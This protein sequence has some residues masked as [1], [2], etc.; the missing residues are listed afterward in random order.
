MS[1]RIVKS[2]IGRGCTVTVCETLSIHPAS[3]WTINWTV[4]TESPIPEI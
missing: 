1:S 4:Y 2:A 3:D